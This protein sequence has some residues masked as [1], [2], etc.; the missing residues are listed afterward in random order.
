[1]TNCGIQRHEGKREHESP[2]VSVKKRNVQTQMEQE[3][4]PGKRYL[5]SVYHY[6]VWDAAF[7]H[8]LVHLMF[9]YNYKPK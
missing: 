5:V 2:S 7:Y 8:Y 9:S 1:M 6:N 3:K 4:L